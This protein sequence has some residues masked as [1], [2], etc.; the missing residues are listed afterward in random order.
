VFGVILKYLQLTFTVNSDPELDFLKQTWVIS[1]ECST[2]DSLP[3]VLSCTRYVSGLIQTSLQLTVTV[4]LTRNLNFSNRTGLCLQSGV[5]LTHFFPSSLAQRY[6]SSVIQTPLQLTVTDIYD[7]EVVNFH[8]QNRFMS[9]DLCTI[10]SI[11]HS[12]LA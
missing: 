12:S 7:P 4:N 10:D 5:Q 8:K 1:A 9:A 6:V 2:L 11:P 3:P